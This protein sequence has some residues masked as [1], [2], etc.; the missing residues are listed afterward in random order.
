MILLDH[1]IAHNILADPA[2]WGVV[3][4]LVGMIITT[5]VRQ[6]NKIA[7]LCVQIKNQEAKFDA[8]VDNVKSEAKEFKQTMI[9]ERKGINKSLAEIAHSQA[10]MN[11]SIARIEGRMNG[12]GS[13]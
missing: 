11:Q 6:T 1:Q 2:F 12:K 4:P 13:K 5:Y 10:T 3:M 8:R 9:A 7:I